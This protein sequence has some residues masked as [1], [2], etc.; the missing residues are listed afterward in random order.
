MRL[1][2]SSNPAV[3]DVRLKRI[4]ETETYASDVPMTIEG[5]LNKTL[6][7]FGI[8]L[9]TGFVGWTYG[10]ASSS[11]MWL[12]LGGGLVL[13]FYTI[14][15]PQHSPYTAPAYAAF[16]GLALGAISAYFEAAY[17]GIVMQAIGLTLGIFFVMLL[18]YR[19]GKIRATP[20]FRK[21]ILI[22]TGGV[23][24]FYILNFVAGMFGGGVSLFNLGWM[25]IGIQLVIIGIAS[26]N[27]ILDFDNIERGA[28][29]EL[30]KFAEWYLGFGLVITL[31]WLYLEL[32]RL[33]ALIAGR[34]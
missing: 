6:I 14:A 3:A 13:A 8:I 26:L 10:Q 11:L 22:A 33:L 1:G 27:L 15:R 30:P 20:K 21:G 28:K 4:A 2:K 29:A 12:G 17:S 5:T 25:G 32:L 18:A 9:L 19:S 24:F 31:V 23:F 16:E 34:D 7:L